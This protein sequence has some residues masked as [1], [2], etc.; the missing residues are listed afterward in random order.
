MVIVD[1]K[2]R[3]FFLLFFNFFWLSAI[4]FCFTALVHSL[5]T[6]LRSISFTVRYFNLRYR[7]S[8]MK[9]AKAI[10]SIFL[11]KI[12]LAAR[13]WVKQLTLCSLWRQLVTL[14]VFLVK[15]MFYAL[16]QI[17]HA[18]TKQEA[19]VVNLFL[20]CFP[21]ATTSC[22]KLYKQNKPPTFLND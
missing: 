18:V 5:A 2:V 17:I 16:S 8:R 3:L 6:L 19:L 13:E 7:T 20:W 14:L 22:E 15:A 4:R 11:L 12:V 9:L 10:F 21:P 1:I